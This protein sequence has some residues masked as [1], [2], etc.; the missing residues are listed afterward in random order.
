M[1]IFSFAFDILTGISSH[2]S[3]RWTLGNCVVLCIC[4]LQN[5]ACEEIN[6]FHFY[7][8]R[9]KILCF[10]LHADIQ[11]FVSV[12]LFRRPPSAW[13]HLI[14]SFYAVRLCRSAYSSRNLSSKLDIHLIKIAKCLSRKGKNY[15]F[16]VCGSTCWGLI[17]CKFFIAFTSGWN[18]ELKKVCGWVN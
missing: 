7:T 10:S 8:A 6:I 9:K 3:A 2:T 16:R 12:L 14:E 13:C 11:D 1:N 17:W 5:E 15:T 4:R 18:N